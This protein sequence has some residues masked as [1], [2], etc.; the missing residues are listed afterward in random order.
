[1]LY[2]TFR[3]RMT[4]QFAGLAIYMIAGAV[5]WSGSGSSLVPEVVVVVVVVVVVMVLILVV[6]SEPLVG[7]GRQNKRNPK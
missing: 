7:L 5:C 1:M 3:L 4:N 6:M 2:A